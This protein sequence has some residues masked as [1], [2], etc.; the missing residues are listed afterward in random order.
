[1]VD[2][3]ALLQAAQN[4]NGV[5][6][7]RL[8]HQ[9]FL[10]TALQ[11]GIFFNILAV[12]IERGGADAVQFAARQGRFEHIARIHRA[13]GF[14]RTHQGVDFINKNQGLAVVFGQIV[15]HGF[16][17][18]FKFAAIFGT[19]N[20][21]GQIEHQQALVA[22]AVGHFAIHDALRQAF[23]NR[24]FAHAGLADEHGIILGAP[25]QHLN[26]AADFIVA[27]DHGVELA[28]AG[29]LG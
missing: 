26:G 14:T 20:Q 21:R 24:G 5:F 9:H 19:G 22:Q 16:E 8:A 1:M 25:L 12:F 6:H 2:F 28:F 4:G 18:L 13:I 7:A 10:E 11:R 29:A 15:E 3:I 23:H 27:A 17:P